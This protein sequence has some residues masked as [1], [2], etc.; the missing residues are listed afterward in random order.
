MNGMMRR[1]AGWMLA[2]F[3]LP[4]VA[5]AAVRVGIVVLGAEEWIPA[6]I[7]AGMR[8]EASRILCFEGVRFDWRG[9]EYLGRGSHWDRVVVVRF[10]QR[11]T[12]GIAL[13]GEGGSFGTTVVSDGKVL[14]FISLDAQRI[15]AAVQRSSAGRLRATDGNLY[16]Q[17]LGRVLAH[18][19]YHALSGSQQ[20]DDD[21]VT[22]AAL[23]GDELAAGS[24]E[25]HPAARTRLMDALRRTE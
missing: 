9:M 19:L 5:G 16:G 20:H 12:A 15:Q 21:G 1:L 10:T 8:K 2:A 11:G 3:W 23:N 24:L 6:A 14:P 17:A 13:K 4:M 22:K 18:E 25:L 7:Q